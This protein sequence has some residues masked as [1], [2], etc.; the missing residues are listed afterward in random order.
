M[1]RLSG[2]LVILGILGVGQGTGCVRTIEEFRSRPIIAPNRDWRLEEGCGYER[3][4]GWPVDFLEGKGIK[5]RIESFFYVPPHRFLIRVQ[6]IL[7]K[8]VSLEIEPSLTE[9]E[10]PD[11]TLLRAKGYNCY[12]KVFA[13]YKNIELPPI[14]GKT[15]LTTEPRQDCLF[16]IFDAPAPKVEEE[17]RFVMRGVTLDGSTL[18][19][20]AM[21]FRPVLTKY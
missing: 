2:V 11:K 18:D 6:F 3:C 20:P 7:E 9:V 15:I 10:L 1:K 5:L 16:F 14:D 19:I 4:G 12:S 8:N 13:D 21:T 17:F